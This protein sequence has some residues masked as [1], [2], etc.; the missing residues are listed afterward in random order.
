[1]QV[2]SRIPACRTLGKVQEDS[3]HLA[4]GADRQTIERGHDLPSAFPTFR[5]ERGSSSLAALFVLQLL[6]WSSWLSVVVI[7]LALGAILTHDCHC[8]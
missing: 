6:F 4:K 7:V 5:H 3:F 2:L 1:M 8:H